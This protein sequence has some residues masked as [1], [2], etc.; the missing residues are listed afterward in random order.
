MLG[1]SFA[2]VRV[3]PGKKKTYERKTDPNRVRNQR[4]AEIRGLKREIGDLGSLV[5]ELQMEDRS[6]RRLLEAAPQTRSNA[7]AGR[8]E[9][10]W[11][12]VCR[13]QQRQRVRAERENLRLRSAVDDYRKRAVA[14]RRSLV[15]SVEAMVRGCVAATVRQRANLSNR[16]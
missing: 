12:E 16:S 13:D 15:R 14:L 5:R 2:S 6:K 11:E 10:V 1:R 3:A 8:E 9:L 7:A 4:N